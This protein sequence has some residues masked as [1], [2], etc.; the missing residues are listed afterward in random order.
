[1]PHRRT[2]VFE[3]RKGEIHERKEICQTQS[4]CPW[5]SRKDDHEG[6]EIVASLTEAVEVERAGIPVGSRFTVATVDLPEEPAT[7]DA[8]S[9]R[10]T[11]Q[12]LA[13]SQAIFAHLLGVSATLVR[14]WEQGH[15]CRQ[16][17]GAASSMR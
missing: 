15:A 13:V 7:Y 11:R 5:R 6:G 14:A 17:G 16:G 12:K 8:A 1:M 10:A 3:Y 2:F 4:S 9:V